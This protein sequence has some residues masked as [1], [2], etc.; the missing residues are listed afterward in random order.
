MS[1]PRESGWHST[2]EE[3]VN[4]NE[5]RQAEHLERAALLEDGYGVRIDDLRKLYGDSI[6]NRFD[7]NAE[8]IERWLRLYETLR[9][10]DKAMVALVG[11]KTELEDGCS[12]G[13]NRR[14]LAKSDIIIV[15]NPH[16]AAI[17]FEEDDR[18]TW[19]QMDAQGYQL[20]QPFMRDERV[21][22]DLTEDPKSIQACIAVR[23]KSAWSGAAYDTLSVIAAGDDFA[24][25][26]NAV[27]DAFIEQGGIYSYE[28]RVLDP[29][30]SR[31]SNAW[32]QIAKKARLAAAAEAV[33]DA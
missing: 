22:D 20:L 8:T 32:W 21:F 19:A 2:V 14:E 10:T 17:T 23:G 15:T 24:E 11:T 4:A 1:E 30:L 3:I 6:L 12:F 26:Y 18:T 9:C 29:A 27:E 7:P 5:I 25:L 16:D 31:L 28:Q 13:R 33:V